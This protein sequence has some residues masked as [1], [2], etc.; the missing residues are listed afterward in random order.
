MSSDDGRIL[1]ERAFCAVEWEDARG[2]L[3]RFESLDVK[4]T[5]LQ[6]DGK[7]I[8]AIFENP[9]CPAVKWEIIREDAST[10][11]C[12]SIKNTLGET[13]RLHNLEPLLVD[14]ERGG[15]LSI[16]SVLNQAYLYLPV[17]G[18]TNPEP[19]YVWTELCR[20]HSFTSE[21]I[22]AAYSPSDCRGFTSGF[23]TTKDMI[24]RFNLSFVPLIR[25]PIVF[26]VACDPEK[27]SIVKGETLSS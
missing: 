25:T 7:D 14:C 1:L 21:G 23:V 6:D 10:V 22:F 9:G 20:S 19:Q 18:L 11:I 16:G 27:M 2:V 5:S 12:I 13:I 26:S 24:S 3:H 8:I 17:D 4:E 15:V